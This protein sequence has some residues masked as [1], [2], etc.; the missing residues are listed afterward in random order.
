MSGARD[1]TIRDLDACGCCEG[2]GLD[3]PAAVWNR[4]GLSQVAYRIG[5]QAGF[6]IQPGRQAEVAVGGPRKAVDTAVLAAAVRVQ[7]ALERQV[8]RIVAAQRALA[9]FQ[10]QFGRDGCGFMIKIVASACWISASS[11]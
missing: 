11:Y 4:P 5:D 10:S 3:A 2:T 9:V 7:A 1:P 6:K 8:G